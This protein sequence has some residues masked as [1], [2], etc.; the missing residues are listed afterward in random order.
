VRRLAIVLVHYP[1]LDRSGEVV[2]TSITNLDIHDI[3]RSSYTYGVERY[4]L[5]HPVKAQRE[6]A[7]RVT[8][9]WTSGSGAN[10]IPDRRPPMESA[11]VVSSVEEARE[12]WGN[13]AEIWVTSAR[14]LPGAMRHSEARRLLCTEGAPVLLLFGTGWG[15]APEIIAQAAVSL[16]PIHSPRSDGYNHLSVRAAAAILLDRLLGGTAQ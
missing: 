12:I 4:F 11:R 8:T 6:L 10:R 3:A 5:V 15:L 2:T 13:D 7:E 16:D 9:H 1:V 14:S